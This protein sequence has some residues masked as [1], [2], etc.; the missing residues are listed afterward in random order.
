MKKSALSRV[1]GFNASMFDGAITLEQVYFWM[2]KTPIP[3][4]WN[5]IHHKNGLIA[6]G[7]RFEVIKSIISRTALVASRKNLRPLPNKNSMRI[8]K[9]DLSTVGFS[10]SGEVVLYDFV[11]DLTDW[12]KD[13]AQRRNGF[14]FVP[15]E[16]RFKKIIFNL[17]NYADELKDHYADKPY[18]AEHKRAVVIFMKLHDDN[19]RELAFD[20]DLR[21]AFN[22]LF[23]AGASERL[24]LILLNDSVKN[25]PSSILKASTFTAFMGDENVGFAESIYKLPVSKKEFGNKH[26]GLLWDTVYPGVLRSF[27]RI[28]S[29][30]EDWLIH[31]RSE[32]DKQDR[33]WEEFLALLGDE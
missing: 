16:G 6:Y 17:K 31:K 27:A 24:Y 22:Y 4:I 12:G 28:E 5:P 21:D 33:E 29:E 23:S 15:A 11:G 19:L 32:L 13:L 18:G 20:E 2:F 3:V 1:L 7:D 14:S 25:F 9:R 8:A 26:I 30:Y 10:G